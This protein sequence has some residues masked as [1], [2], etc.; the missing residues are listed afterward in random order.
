MKHR[1]DVPPVIGNPARVI[2]DPKTRAYLYGIAVPVVALLVGLGVVAD[3]TAGLI[4][5]VAAGVLAMSGLGLA[6][7]NTDTKS[8]S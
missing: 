6:T 3:G 5:N 7:A 1:K 2:A 8:G 4:L